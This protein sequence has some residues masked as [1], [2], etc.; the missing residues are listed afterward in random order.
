MTLQDASSLTRTA[1]RLIV[2]CRQA[3]GSPPNFTG[4][5]LT[6]WGTKVE[7]IEENC[8]VTPSRA[9]IWLPQDRWSRLDNYIPIW[10]D[11]IRIR[12]EENA[13]LFIGFV[14]ERSPEF[15]G[16][17][18]SDPGYENASVTCLDARWLLRT[19]SPVTG[20]W[21]RGYDD[22]D[23]QLFPVTDRCRLFD[24]RRTI[25]NADG[26][27]NRAVTPLYYNSGNF[28]VL[29]GYEFN[30][31]SIPIFDDP[32]FGEYWTAGDM[33]AYVTSPLCNFAGRWFPTGPVGSLP[34]LDHS[35]WNKV[36]HHVVIDGLSTLEAIDRICKLIGW[37]FRLNLDSFR[38]Y[39]VFFKPGGAAWTDRS[40]ASP[41]ILHELH[42][43]AVGE[44]ISVAVWNRRAML[45]DMRLD[46]DIS[47]TVNMPWL[48]GAP[49]RF[50]FTAELVP[51]WPDV[52][53]RP[54]TSNGNS[55]LYLTEA[56]LQKLTNPS[57]KPFFNLYHTKGSG[58][59]LLGPLRDVGR[60]WTLN[61]SGLYSLSPYDR[62]KFFDFATVVPSGYSLGP[63]GSRLFG[64]FARRLLPCLSADTNRDSLGIVVEFSLDAGQ[65]W[66]AINCTIR[67]L[68]D[69]AG[70]FI[71]EPNLAELLDEKNRQI[72]EPWAAEAQTKLEY[73]ELN[74]WTSLCMDIL[75]SRSFKDRQLLW[76]S[77]A[78]AEHNWQT[79]VRV[80][81]SVQLDQRLFG[82]AV[83]FTR[84]GSPFNHAEVY[85]FSDKYFLDRRSAA[86]VFSQSPSLF[87]AVEHDH[88]SKIATHAL[89]IRDANEDMSI[90]GSFSL[91]RLWLGDGASIARF[92]LGDGIANIS[93]RQHYTGMSFGGSAAYPE[94]VKIV[95]R[96]ETQTQTLH[97]RD[98]RFA[99]VTL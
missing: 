52:L 22:Y 17:S 69:E 15:S 98:S 78:S 31:S 48:Q 34:G 76:S 54:D 10:G 91:E 73:E 72:G 29:G 67:S 7:L 61:E 4:Q 47:R 49:Q 70:I 6:V 41:T 1:Q 27:P 32:K 95:Y 97:T 56:E 12:T 35:D 51:A 96:P 55:Q 88:A 42:A 23:S 14:T 28:P 64:P 86:S 94:I 84:S 50:E 2:E 19:A 9:V 21:A 24:G 75:W 5:W 59:R 82:Y 8:G 13:T 11:M 20:Q 44:D 33:M 36:I 43:P 71:D 38:P 79:R 99:E 30:G 18:D 68:P 85:D 77:S 63:D 26:R 74:Y 39:L 62:G 25:F 81:A 93:G 40:F 58:H 90:S 60:K 92:Q 66:Q 80:T 37:D 87:G 65:S 53:L 45:S 83:P 16:G 57:A 89:A 46:E 3:Y